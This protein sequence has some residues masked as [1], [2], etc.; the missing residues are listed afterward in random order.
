M[1]EK[2]T[3]GMVCFYSF[4][5]NE[6]TKK[7]LVS[8]SPFVLFDNLT[9]PLDIFFRQEIHLLNQIGMLLKHSPL[10]GCEIVIQGE[11]TVQLGHKSRM[12]YSINAT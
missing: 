5:I 9:F 4:G 11:N 6:G 8:P 3:G 12:S 7:K 10:P 1:P 2:V